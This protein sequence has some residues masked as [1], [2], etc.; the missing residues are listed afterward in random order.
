MATLADIS[1]ISIQKDKAPAYITLL[2]NK[3]STSPTPSTSE[4]EAIV[5]AVV[6]ETPVVARQVLSELARLLVEGASSIQHALHDV[7]QA[8]LK[9]VAPRGVTFDEQVSTDSRKLDHRGYPLKSHLSGKCYEES[10][11]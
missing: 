4:I 2:A 9:I 10:I 6:A 8:V 3:L 1:R 11:G 5:N 7:L